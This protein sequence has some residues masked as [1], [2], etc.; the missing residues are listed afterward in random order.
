MF[1]FF[2]KGP[3]APMPKRSFLE[4]EEIAKDIVGQE[5]IDVK[6]LDVSGG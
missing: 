4:W 2:P 3:D 6:V 1:V 5:G